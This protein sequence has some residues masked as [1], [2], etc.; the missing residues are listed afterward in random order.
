M[1]IYLVGFMGCGKSS[2]GKKLAALLNYNF[3]DLDQLIEESFSL[4]VEEIFNSKGEESFRIMEQKCLQSTFGMDDIVVATGGGTPAFFENMNRINENGISV[5]I[6]LPPL[7]IEK[8]L[9]MS[10]KPRPLVKNLSSEELLAFV[11]DKSEERRPFYL[12]A[13]ISINGINLKPEDIIDA[14][15]KKNLL[16]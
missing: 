12:S 8:R 7:A 2:V 3:I 1:R 5:F 6:D 4:S 9:R 16:Q 11:I 14:L 15:N 13:N 10:R